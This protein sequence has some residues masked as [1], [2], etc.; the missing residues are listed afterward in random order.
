MGDLR[1]NLRNMSEWEKRGKRCFCSEMPADTGASVA[2]GEVG[3]AA[4]LAFKSSTFLWL[5]QGKN[6][7]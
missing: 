5:T 3:A 1:L 7:P 2:S 6:V 4:K